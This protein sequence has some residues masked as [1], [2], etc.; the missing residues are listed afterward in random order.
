MPCAVHGWTGIKRPAS[1]P[2]RIDVKYEW[3]LSRS[4]PEGWIEEKVFVATYED[5]KTEDWPEHIPEDWS[6]IGEGDCTCNV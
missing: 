2:V 6:G 4:G 5:G 1:L 3:A